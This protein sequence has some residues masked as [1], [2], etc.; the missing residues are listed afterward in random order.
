MDAVEDTNEDA[1][2][3]LWVTETVSQQIRGLPLLVP[4]EDGQRGYFRRIRVSSS[5]ETGRYG[6]RQIDE[7]ERDWFRQGGERRVVIL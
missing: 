4:V 3:C 6:R 5:R 7:D 2:R 1:V